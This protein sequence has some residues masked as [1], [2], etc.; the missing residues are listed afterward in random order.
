[1]RKPSAAVRAATCVSAGAAMLAGCSSDPGPVAPSAPAKVELGG[2]S[3]FGPCSGSAQVG[4]YS[5]TFRPDA[6]GAGG[7]VEVGAP[8]ATV[9]ST[10]QYSLAQAGPA[11]DAAITVAFTPPW[12]GTLRRDYKNL[13]LRYQVGDER[14]VRHCDL[15]R[16]LSAP[17]TG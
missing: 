1:M 4:A 14:G 6:T 17:S 7:T 15:Q 5:F 8:D 11:G 16:T 10:V 9:R 12:K 3:W 13:L 2:T